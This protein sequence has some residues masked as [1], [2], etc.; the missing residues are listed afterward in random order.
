M[1]RIP[2]IFHKFVSKLDLQGTSNVVPDCMGAMAPFRAYPLLCLTCL[3]GRSF[4]RIEVLRA[5]DLGKWRA[6][7]VALRVFISPLAACKVTR[8]DDFTTAS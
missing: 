5:T 7:L 6:L 3:E 2:N 1:Q 4:P 8:R